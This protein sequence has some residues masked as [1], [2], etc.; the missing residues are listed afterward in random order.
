MTG[1]KT[2]VNNGLYK[3]K[4]TGPR[5]VSQMKLRQEHH[6]YKQNDTRKSANPGQNTARNNRKPIN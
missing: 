3:Y 2:T 5:Y 6:Q 1:S 4:A